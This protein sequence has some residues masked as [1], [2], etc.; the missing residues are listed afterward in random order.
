MKRTL[1]DGLIAGLIG[2][3]AVALFYAVVNALGGHS[4]FHTAE[5]LGVVVLGQ[6]DGSG[7]ARIGDILAI[8]GLHLIS[9]LLMGVAA[10]VLLLE[11][12]LHP[13]FWYI[14][15]FTFLVG[16]IATVAA[17]AVLTVRLTGEVP[18]WTIFAANGLAAALA[19]LFLV[20]VHPELW[21][22]LQ[23]AGDPEYP[24]GS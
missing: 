20:R 11:T 13:A 22:I 15:L 6:G 3:T 9:F 2:Y 14:T 19:A 10:A 1:L 4:L 18:G 24:A 12:E 8:N 16:F 21:G 7:V 17:A 5:L 23:R